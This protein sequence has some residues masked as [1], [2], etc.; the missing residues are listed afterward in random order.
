MDT[1]YGGIAGEPHIPDKIDEYEC[2]SDKWCP[3]S[4]NQNIMQT[5]DS[6]PTPAVLSSLQDEGVDIRPRFWDNISKSWVLVDTGAQVSA[7]M[8]K[9]GDIIDPSIRLETV[10]GSKMPCYGKK[11]MTFRLGRKEYHQEVFITNTN[12][13]IILFGA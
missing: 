4:D 2:L 10:D 11:T 1:L 7:T 9:P 5:V 6:P 8:P 12:E 3:S 13:T